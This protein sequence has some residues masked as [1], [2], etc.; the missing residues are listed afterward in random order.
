MNF[1][2]AKQRLGERKQSD[3]QVFWILVLTDPDSERPQEI[4]WPSSLSK[5]FGGHGLMESQLM[6]G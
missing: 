6:S 3:F 4:L 2:K 1:Y 5:G